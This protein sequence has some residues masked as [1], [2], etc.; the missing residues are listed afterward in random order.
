LRSLFD[1]VRVLCC[2][3]RDLASSL[4]LNL[5]LPALAP[6][7]VRVGLTERVGR[8]A[9]ADEPPARRELRVAEQELVNEVLFPAI[10]RAAYPDDG[11][12]FLT[13]AELET[14]RGIPVLALPRPNDGPGLAAIQAFAPDVIVTIRYGAILRPAA[15]AVPRYGVLNLHSGLLPA[16]RGVLATFRALMND[17]AE[18]G[19]TLH[20]IVDAS[21]DTGDIIAQAR[22]PVQRQ[23]S[24]LW[25]VLALYAPGVALLTDALTRLASGDPVRGTPQPADGAYYS[26]PNA[27]EWDELLRRGWRVADPSDLYTALERYCP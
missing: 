11:R 27:D 16:Y 5:L 17:D 22:I 26:A 24:L 10:E 25:H 6:H 1:V 4:A 15:I 19:C 3:N 8:G 13:F 14:S 21:I 7:E 12:R 2:V 23:R 18:I 9:P 20:H